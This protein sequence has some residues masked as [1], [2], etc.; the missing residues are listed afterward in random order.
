MEIK[1]KFSIG[2]T[3]WTVRDCKALSFEVQGI[4]YDGNVSYYGNPVYHAIPES[5]C[6]LT[7]E[8]LMEYITK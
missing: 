7:Q 5:Q 6:F 3:L 4:Q 1:T 2:Q 8:E